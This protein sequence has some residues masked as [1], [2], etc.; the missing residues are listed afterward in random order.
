MEGGARLPGRHARRTAPQL[1]V[2][3]SVKVETVQPTGSFKVRA[4][5]RC[6]PPTTTSRA[7]RRRRAGRNHGLGWPTQLRAWRRSRSWCRREPRRPRSLRS[8]SSTCGS[9]CTGG[10]QGSRDP[11]PG[12][13]RGRGQ[14]L[15]LALQRP[16]CH[17]RSGDGPRVGGADAAL[18]TVVVP[19]GG[20]GLLAGV[21]LGLEDCGVRVVGVESEASP[22]MSTA[23]AAGAIVPISVEPTVADGLAGNLEPGAV[24]VAVAPTTVSRS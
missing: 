21:A 23:L 11:R 5:L 18:G 15:R 12:I 6:L 2:S 10:L 20:G 14:P 1:G 22:S 17:R 8:S 24:T 3:V 19:C 4:W 7:S 9:C 16:R 13:G